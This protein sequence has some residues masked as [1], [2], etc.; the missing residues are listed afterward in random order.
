[1]GTIRERAA[2]ARTA[3]ERYP[4][5][6]ERFEALSRR[7]LPDLAAFVLRVTSPEM[8]DAIARAIGQDRGRGCAETGCPACR[9]VADAIM[10]L[11]R[12][13]T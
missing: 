13:G 3:S 4:V 8:R 7:D 9:A 1:M 10:A 6:P 12:E 5:D 2:D 11:L